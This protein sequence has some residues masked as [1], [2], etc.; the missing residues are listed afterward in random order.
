MPRLKWL[1]EIFA[2]TKDEC[3]LDEIL[4][5]V[6]DLILERNREKLFEKPIDR[7]H[8]D[9][10]TY[11]RRLRHCLEYH[12]EKAQSVRPCCS[13]SEVVDD[14]DKKYK[15]QN[16]F[17]LVVLA[18]AVVLQEFKARV[19]FRPL[20]DKEFNSVTQPHQDLKT[21][22]KVND[23]DGNDCREHVFDELTGG[24]SD[25]QEQKLNAILT[26]MEIDT[27]ERMKNVIDKKSGK[28]EQEEVLDMIL[29]GMEPD[30]LEQVKS[31]ILNAQLK[32]SKLNLVITA[33]STILNPPKIK[34]VKNGGLITYKG[35]GD[36]IRW[37]HKAIDRHIASYYMMQSKKISILDPDIHDHKEPSPYHQVAVRDLM[38]KM[39]QR[40][41]K[42]DWEL[43]ELHY[44]RNMSHKEICE[45]K[46]DLP[47]S[48]KD[49]GNF[50]TKMRQIRERIKKQL[51]MKE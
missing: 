26:G 47:R 11:S 19:V 21:G 4:E 43:L 2:K 49:P 39:R 33:K 13:A 34:Q 35:K 3:W 28:L 24:L 36:L 8:E 48:L 14:I 51:E 44:M 10:P 46:K 18:V 16:V 25:R 41:E 5:P 29:A 27:L 31:V 9:R 23:D 50:S 42:N 12:V 38:D 6:F 1:Q 30:Q 7:E 20:Y 32:I 45:I 17:D 40:L 37:L 22:K 15:Q